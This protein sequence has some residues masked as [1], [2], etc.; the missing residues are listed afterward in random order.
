[1]SAAVGDFIPM[2]RASK[3]IPRQKRWTVSF[4]EA[5]D[6]VKKLAQKKG[7]RKVIGFSLETGDWLGRSR[8][9]LVRKQLDGIVANYYSPRHNPFGP[10]RVHAA[11]LDREKT[12]VLHRP[13]KAA[14]A[15]EILD[16]IFR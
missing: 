5:P 3:K 16:W 15:R 10:T 14:L 7:N 1:M 11:L 4:R 6:L 13:S 2:R 9:K 12:R 8:R